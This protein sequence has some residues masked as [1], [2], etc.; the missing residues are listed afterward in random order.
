[1][2]KKPVP[3]PVQAQDTTVDLLVIGSGTGLGLST[4]FNIV[5]RHGGTMRVESTPGRGT[6]FRVHLPHLR[7]AIGGGAA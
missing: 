4:S 6:T 3:A 5:R 1:M 2:A 7:E